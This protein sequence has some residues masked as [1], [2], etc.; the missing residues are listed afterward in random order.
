MGHHQ[1][2]LR[3]AAVRLGWVGPNQHLPRSRR[4]PAIDRIGVV[5][6]SDAKVHLRHAVAAT[7]GKRA[8]AA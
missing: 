6:P 4:S 3:V 5:D 7:I 1:G 8:G 2:W